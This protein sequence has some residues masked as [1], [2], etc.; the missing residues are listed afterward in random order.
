M[1]DKLLLLIVKYTRITLTYVV[2]IKYCD[3]ALVL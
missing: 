3:F 1:G 2:G